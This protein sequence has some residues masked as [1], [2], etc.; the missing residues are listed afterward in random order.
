[1]ASRELIA[2]RTMY[3]I[4]N[5]Y[6]LAFAIVFNL[7]TLPGTRL[8]VPCMPW[9][10]ML[11]AALLQ[12]GLHPL[13]HTMKKSNTNMHNYEHTLSHALLPKRN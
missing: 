5:N 4:V 8:S 3:K 1:M 10:R 9:K 6:C 7:K 2:Y 12:T 13:V 11:D